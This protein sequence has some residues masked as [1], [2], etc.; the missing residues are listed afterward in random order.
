MKKGRDEDAPYAS[1]SCFEEVL[2]E[3]FFPQGL[4]EA[5][6]REFLTLKQNSLSAHEYGLKFTQPSRYAPEMVKDIGV[7]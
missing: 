3:R 1:W 6:V 2:L 7:R 4:R 5:K